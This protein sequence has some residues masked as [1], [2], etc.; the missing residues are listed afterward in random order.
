MKKSFF[1]Q[2]ESALSQ[3]QGQSANTKDFKWYEDS[4]PC[5]TACPADT[6]IPGYLEAIYKKESERKRL[7][8]DQRRKD[9]EGK[10]GETKLVIRKV[11]QERDSA[12]EMNDEE[13]EEKAEREL[14]ELK[15]KWKQLLIEEDQG[16]CLKYI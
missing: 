11:I 5:R 6:D 7:D 1:A 3:V 9:L 4:V 15:L 10:K 2:H 13:T 16:K 12:W 14:K 8:L